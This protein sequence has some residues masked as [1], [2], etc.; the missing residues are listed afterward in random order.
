VTRTLVACALVAACSYPTKQYDPTGK[1]TCSGVPLPPGAGSSVTIS[2]LVSDAFTGMPI[3]NAMVDGT[4]DGEMA[5][6][7]PTTT[8]SNGAFSVTETTDGV[9]RDLSLVVTGSGYLPTNVTPSTTLGSDL[10]IEP[11]GLFTQDDLD[12]VGSA[13]MQPPDGSKVQGI[14]QV[15]DCN[16]SALAGATVSTDP[17]AAGIVYADDTLAPDLSATSTAAIGVAFVFGLQPGTPTISGEF[18]DG[19]ALRSHP[20]TA[21]VGQVMLSLIQP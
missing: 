14:V 6:G 9:A 3:A 15:Q 18:E 17:P 11:L 20:A 19:T 10:V 21:T 12:M 7:F 4:L 2:G 13:A 16:G 8:S 1:Y 5:S